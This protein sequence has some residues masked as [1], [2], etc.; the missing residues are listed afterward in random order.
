MKTR[1][2]H[3]SFLIWSFISLS[4]IAQ[5]SPQQ[6]NIVLFDDFKDNQALWPELETS[7][8]SIKVNKNRRMYVL[9]YNTKTSK[10]ALTAWKNVGLDESRDYSISAML[11][12]E[13]GVKN[14]G[15]GLIWGARD[16]FF[17]SF[18]VSPGGFYCIGKVEN[19]L[20]NDITTGKNGWVKSSAVVTGRKAFNK[21]TLSKI[22]AKLHFEINGIK[23][24]TMN[25]LP[26][27]GSNVGFNVNNKQKILVDWVKI[28]YLN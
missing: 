12:K 4:T 5:T 13:S 23:V 2:L 15:Y 19:G 27:Y 16:D 20:W 1:V 7:I 14:F 11:Y 28:T 9:K 3:L 22:G 8:S 21:L 6:E 26:T 25:V 10:D 17:Y 24:A 18:L